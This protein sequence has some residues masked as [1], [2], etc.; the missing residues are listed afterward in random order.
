VLIIVIFIKQIYYN[1]KPAVQQLDSLRLQAM[2]QQ[3]QQQAQQAQNAQQTTLPS[4][5]M[6]S[7]FIILQ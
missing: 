6:I 2:A 4:N 7:Y 5:G 3:V 1:G